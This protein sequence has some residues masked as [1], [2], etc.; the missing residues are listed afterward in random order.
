MAVRALGGIRT[1]RMPG[2]LLDGGRKNVRILRGCS[3]LPLCPRRVRRAAKGVVL[4]PIVWRYGLHDVPL[5]GVM[6]RD[7]LYTLAALI[8]VLMAMAIAGGIEAGKIL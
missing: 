1:L 2:H 6:T 7:D 3:R 5:G 4:G 8:F